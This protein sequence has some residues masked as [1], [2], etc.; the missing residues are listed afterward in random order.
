MRELIQIVL[1]MVAIGGSALF[2]L[3]P[4]SSW[5]AIAAGIIVVIGGIYFICD[6]K[7]GKEDVN[8][9]TEGEV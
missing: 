6:D 2:A 3:T 9:E 7:E 1:V 4:R 5:V 8:E